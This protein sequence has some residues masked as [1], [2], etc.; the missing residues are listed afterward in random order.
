MRTSSFKSFGE[1]LFLL[2]SLILLA[3][4]LPVGFAGAAPVIEFSQDGTTFQPVVLL[5]STM[6][7]SSYYS[8]SS[9]AGHPAF[10]VARGVDTACL[11]WDSTHDI[12]SL[13]FISG[14]RAN[15]RASGTVTVKGLP[16]SSQLTLSDD[17]GEFKYAKRTG[18]LTGHFAY[19]NSTDGFVMSGLET[20]TFEATL[21]LSHSSGIKSFRLTV[22]DPNSGGAFLPLDLHQPLYLRNTGSVGTGGGIPVVGAGVP[23][24]TGLGLLGIVTAWL[25]KRP[26]RVTH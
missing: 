24:P 23:E 14:G 10:G 6:K 20:A 18:T 9:H 12:L 5:S 19:Q 16:L 26:R 13:I 17:P 8:Y 15:D 7:A 1:L 21:K 25:F 3:S 11:Y 22:G 2:C 4:L